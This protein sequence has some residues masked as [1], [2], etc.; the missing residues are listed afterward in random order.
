MRLRL[1]L[2]RRLLMPV[3]V[4]ELTTDVTVDD[5]GATGGAGGSGGG[6]DTQAQWEKLEAARMLGERLSR[7]AERTRSEAY[8]D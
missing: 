1:W 8:G 3:R 5:G 6:G 4:D 7:D 2:W